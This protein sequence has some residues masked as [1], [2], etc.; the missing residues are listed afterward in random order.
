M[1]GSHWE[2]RL[3]MNEIMTGS[4]DTRSVVSRMTLALLEDSGW[5]QANYS[6]ADRLDWG[7]NQGTEFVTSPCN[8]WKGAYHCNTTQLSGCTYNREAEGY[9]PIVS[10][11]GDLP[12]WAQYFPQ[13]NKGIDHVQEIVV[14]MV[15]AI[16]MVSVSAKVGILALTAPPVFFPL[17][18]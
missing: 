10:Y 4:V 13:A 2:K 14:D 6:M 18:A 15:R 11:N 12:K 7:R 16:Q 3:L 1:A 17:F 9:C 8:H 5:Y